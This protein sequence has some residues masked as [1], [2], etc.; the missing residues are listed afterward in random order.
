MAFDTTMSNT[1]LES[2]GYTLLE[3]KLGKHLY[4]GIIFEK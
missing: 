3:E 4:V 2:D 1:G